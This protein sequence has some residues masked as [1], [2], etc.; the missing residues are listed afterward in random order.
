MTLR[1]FR[2]DRYKL[3]FWKQQKSQKGVLRKSLLSVVYWRNRL[4]PIKEAF[5]G[6]RGASMLS[7]YD[8]G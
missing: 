6:C 7:S 1:N 4:L 5:T 2:K 3:D 8:C